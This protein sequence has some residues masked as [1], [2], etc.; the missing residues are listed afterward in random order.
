MMATAAR[1]NPELRKPSLS[2]RCGDAEKDA[3]LMVGVAALFCFFLHFFAKL[4]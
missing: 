2:P 4:Q 3:T 1:L